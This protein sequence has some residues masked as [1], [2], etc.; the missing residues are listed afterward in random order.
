MVPK[1]FEPLKF[2]SG[3]NYVSDRDIFRQYYNCCEWT[4]ANCSIPETSCPSNV[5]SEPV[6]SDELRYCLRRVVRPV[7]KLLGTN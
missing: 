1:M 4:T 3:K 6:F 2:D 7:L 5:A